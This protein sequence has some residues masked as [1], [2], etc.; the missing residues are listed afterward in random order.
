MAV[1]RRWL[2]R[3]CFLC[4]VKPRLLSTLTFYICLPVCLRWLQF[5]VPERNRH[6]FSEIKEE[7]VKCENQTPNV[8]QRSTI[9]R[10]KAKKLRAL[11]TFK[12]III[13]F[14]T[15]WVYSYDKMYACVWGWRVYYHYFQWFPISSAHLFIALTLN[16]HVCVYQIMS[17]GNCEHGVQ[18][19]NEIAKRFYQGRSAK[20]RSR[21]RKPKNLGIVEMKA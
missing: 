14:C 13:F 3:C 18:T 20:V 4:N 6:T 16:T 9:F 10:L 1:Y 15:F 11:E 17:Y 5:S 12:W 2:C 19:P 7:R 21:R 8:I